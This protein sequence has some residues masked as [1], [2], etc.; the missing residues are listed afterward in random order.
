MIT[1]LLP[2]ELHSHYLDNEENIFPQNLAGNRFVYKDRLNWYYSINQ[3]LCISNN[4]GLN[5]FEEDFLGLSSY[6]AP[7]Y[8]LR[9][10][11]SY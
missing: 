8:Q 6:A 7:H 3:Y 10:Y 4:S 11:H 9:K 2:I 1:F 5:S